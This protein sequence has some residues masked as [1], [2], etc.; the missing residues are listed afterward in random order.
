MTSGQDQPSAEA[1]H[2]SICGG[3]PAGA[4]FAELQR[5]PVSAWIELNLG[6]EREDD[7]WVRT[8]TPMNLAQAA[9]KLSV[10]SG[11]KEADC[12]SFLRG[13]L[14]L[15]YSTRDQSGGSLF[16]FRLHQFVAGG[17]DVFG[18]LEPEGMRYLTLDGQT[19]EP[20]ANREKLLFNF[21]F[22]RE[23][24]QEYA[25]V[26]ATVD[27]RII[28]RIEPRELFDRSSEDDDVRF[29][30]FM[31]DPA[32]RFDL[33]NVEDSFPE[34][35]LQYDDRGVKLKPAYRKRAPVAVRVN[36]LG[37]A[38]DGGMAGWLI[39]GSFRF[40]LNPECGAY[41]DSSVRSDLTKL[42]GLTTEG[43]SSATTVL[44][45]ASLRYLL[46]DSGTLSERAKKVL[47][48]TDNRQDASLQ[49]GHFNDFVQV[50]LLRGALLAAIDDAPDKSLIDETLTQ[51]VFD[52]LHLADADFSA[53]P[54]QKGVAADN[55]RRA[56]RDVLGY[57]L[58]F[59]LRRGWRITNPNLE[60]LGL[61]AIDYL[62]L[63]ECC[64]DREVWSDAPDLLANAIPETRKHAARLVLETLRRQ[65]CV[66]T[67]Y[68]DP[69]EQEQIKNRSHNNLREPW[70]LTEDEQLTASSVLI[71]EAAPRHWRGEFPVVFA[72]FRSRLGRMLCRGKL[73]GG[74]SNP[75]L[76]KRFTPELY[77][78]VIRHILSALQRYGIVENVEIAGLGEG[79]RVSGGALRWT[80]ADDK[81]A[82]TETA[83]LRVTDNVFFKTLYR[84]VAGAL[85]ADSRFLHRLEA[86]EHTAQVDSDVREER[87]ARFRTAA[88]PVLF[89]SPTME[90]GVDIA[91]L[92]VVY[93]RNLPPTPANYAQRSG[94]AGRSGQPAL[95]VSY[96]CGEIAT[97]S[98]FLPQSRSHGG[99]QRQPAGTRSRKRGPGPEPSSRRLAGRDRRKAC[100]FG[101]RGAGPHQG[102]G[103][104]DPRY[105]RDHDEPGGCPA[106]VNCAWT[107]HNGDAGG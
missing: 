76:P 55:T 80:L 6:L 99:R 5:H 74:Q 43:R 30:F 89:C 100:H 49:A 70:G 17:G 22:C 106:E 88:L 90:L 10:D 31:P 24:G 69:L 81:T 12:A 16:A 20:D 45:L 82:R 104:A 96:C 61:L 68:L 42:T 86:R 37:V 19:Y 85:R 34:D 18:T 53:N 94:R 51:R 95:V 87:E 28:K 44:T 102:G 98:V 2:K 65:L 32:A 84:N 60:Q 73:W 50:L 67:R 101:V 29:G 79:Y 8:R 58:Y 103:P 33:E 41:Y 75:D 63:D 13:Y 23:C 66:K 52:Q 25:P 78:A 83:G 97:R 15:A 11:A 36:P 62:S 56:L 47:G 107:C 26:W 7:K 77:D 48:F 93:M 21:C 38:D 64:A 1:L 59:D 35:W 40:C 14:L 46:E 71:P 57:R 92:N 105:H 39:P 91:E 72:S 27:K 4:S 3:V 54:N 9:R